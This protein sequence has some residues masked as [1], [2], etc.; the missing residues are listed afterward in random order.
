MA[1]ST[2][3]LSGL[4]RLR[5]IAALTAITLT[6]AA[7][8]SDAVVG[9][10]SGSSVRARVVELV[11]TARSRG[12]KC[13]SERF[14]AAPALGVSRQLNEAATDHAR[15]MAR[16]KYFEHRGRDGSQP[17]DRV[18]SA[19]YRPRLSGENIAYGPESA[20]EVVAGWLD[21][22]GHCAN[23]MDPRFQDIGVGLATGRKR[24]QIYWVQTFGAPI[25]R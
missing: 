17:K 6:A 10:D 22:P 1:Q 13:G 25:S 24:G 14:A 4:S 20:E 16:R 2:H 7:S 23:I 5:C 11:N 9:R 19:G 12:R 8:A 3:R 15:D 21:S 18:L